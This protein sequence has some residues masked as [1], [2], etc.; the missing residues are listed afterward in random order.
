MPARGGVLR[1]LLADDIDSLDPHRAARPSSWFVARALHRGLL[2]YPN[3]AFPAG[4]RPVPDLATAL[5]SIDAGGRT[6]TFTLRDGVRFASAPLRA[7][8]VRASLLRVRASGAGIAPFLQPV[9]RIDTPDE[10]T[11]VITLS[12]ALGD[13]PWILAHP[14]AAIVPADTRP[15][16]TVDPSRI[17]GLGPYRVARY[18]PERRVHLER[19]DLWNPSTDPVR[20]ANLDRLELSVGID[21]SEAAR[22]VAS[23]N[24]DLILDDG[25][26]DIAPAPPMP[27]GTMRVL[28]V[29]G[30]CV[31]AMFVNPTLMRRATQR[32]AAAAIARTAVVPDHAA[33]AT[34]LLPPTVF[35][36]ATPVDVI[37]P[38]S[39]RATLRDGVALTI[40]DTPRDRGEATA[41]RAAFARAGVRLSVRR[42]TPALLPAA[43]ARAQAGL[44]TWC[45]DWPGLAGRNVIGTLLGIEAA[46]PAPVRAD[47]GPALSNAA[48][49]RG[50]AALSRWAT[51]DAR[52]TALGVIVP[53]WWPSAVVVGSSRVRGL[54]GAP[55]FPRGDPANMWLHP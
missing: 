44:I 43:H 8:D 10:R 6:Y 39:A 38:P 45:A 50:S 7:R 36:H 12:R 2:A 54:G 55:M 30:G 18:E 24:A 47:L 1:T 29:A 15:A 49:T 34:G 17:D 11:I 21:P 5:P 35:G 41:L 9:E 25:P 28:H 51:V 20:A 22:A 37:I 27:T 16:G 23:G 46:S 3:A 19:N 52:A 4:A 53:L 32:R 31:R 14:Q 42:V 33:R 40:G 13:L 48:A 26:P